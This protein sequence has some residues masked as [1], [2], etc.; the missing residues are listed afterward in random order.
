M[1]YIFLA[2]TLLASCSSIAKEEFNPAPHLIKSNTQAFCNHEEY[3]NCMKISKSECVNSF[4][5]AINLCM[6]SA[7]PEL[8]MPSPVCVTNNYIK[9][10]KVGTQI[11]K[12][13]EKITEAIYEELK[14][15]HMPNKAVKRD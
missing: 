14:E 1:K 8:N 9:N 2:I 3:I 12:S 15:K 10:T 6:K 5:N 13:C 4:T 11:A 7:H